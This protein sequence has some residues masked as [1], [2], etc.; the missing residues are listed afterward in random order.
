M[1]LTSPVLHSKYPHVHSINM[2]FL[3]IHVHLSYTQCKIYP[4]YT[5]SHGIFPHCFFT[6]L[7][8]VDP[9]PPQS[10]PS[11]TPSLSHAVENTFTTDASI[12]LD[13]ANGIGRGRQG[14]QGPKNGNRTK[15]AGRSRRNNPSP[16][17]EDGLEVNTNTLSFITHAVN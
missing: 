16:P 14:Q 5:P 10:D 12:K 7:K 2:S 4:R 3:S 1:Y 9:T 13:D 17:P 8:E 6:Y 15:T 11:T